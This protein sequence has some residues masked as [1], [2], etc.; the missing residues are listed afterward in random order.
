MK[1]IVNDTARDHV[2]SEGLRPQDKAPIPNSNA[3]TTGPR[4]PS[5]PADPFDDSRFGIQRPLPDRPLKR[6]L[7]IAGALFV[8]IIGSPLYLAVWIAVRV[9]SKGPGIYWSQ[10]LGRN[11]EAF[12]MPKFRSMCVDAPVI[13][14]EQL[15]SAHS[16][17]TPIGHFLRNSS[18]DELPQVWS[19]LKGDM[20][21]IGPRPLLPTDPGIRARWDFPEAMAVRPGVT[22]LAQV[23]GRNLVSPRLKARYDAFYARKGGWGLDASILWK[24]ALVMLSRKGLM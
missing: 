8:M 18:L 17:I 14:R 12:W 16:H 6:L 24:T 20:S 22:G 3:A 23:R 1:L 19:I 5:T 21:I 11:G 2:A 13:P 10:R 9:T 4:V 15:S 7:D